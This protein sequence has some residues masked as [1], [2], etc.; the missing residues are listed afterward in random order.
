M[1]EQFPHNDL[2]LILDFS[3]HGIVTLTA[4]GENYL[5]A[6]RQGSELYLFMPSFFLTH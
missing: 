6:F 4:A 1:E 5:P 3:S 2:L